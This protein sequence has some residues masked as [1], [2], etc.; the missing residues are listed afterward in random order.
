MQDT[1]NLVLVPAEVDAADVPVVAAGGIADS[2]G[3][4][5]AFA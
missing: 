4:Q 3:Y 2:R 5:A 1:L